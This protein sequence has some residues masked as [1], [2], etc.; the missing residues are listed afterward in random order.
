VIAGQISHTLIVSTLLN[1]KQVTNTSKMA[2]AKFHQ[3]PIPATVVA[4]FYFNIQN[5]LRGHI[6]LLQ[7][8]DEFNKNKYHLFMI[9]FIYLIINL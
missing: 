3:D 6:F 4:E 2:L 7:T 1:L 9:M 5:D 8:F